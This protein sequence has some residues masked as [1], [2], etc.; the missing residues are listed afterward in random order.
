M[1][2]DDNWQ[3]YKIIATGDGEKLEK[4]GN[5]T[6]LRPDPQAIWHAQKPLKEYKGLSAR[7]L[8]SDTGGG[9]WEYFK[10]ID[11]W[12]VSW[13]NL[14]FAV[15]P[16]GFKH[17][18][19]F[20]EQAVNWEIMINLIKNAQK[21]VRVLNLFA[22]TGGATVACAYAGAEVCHVDAAKN[23][24]DRAKQN[25]RLSGL[26]D[27][28]V[29]YIVDDC[30]KF[31]AREIKRGK[32]Y[33]AVILDPPSYGRGANG[34][35]WKLENDIADFLQLVK[36]VLTPKP[37]FVLLNSYTTGLQPTVLKNLLNS[38]LKGFDGSTEAYEVCL[39]TQEDGIFLPCGASGLF[40]GKNDKR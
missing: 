5:V 36:G 14:T 9:R 33:D 13:K 27:K 25:V 2:Y 11:E 21:P 6:L 10:P 34:E 19:L 3:D 1:R 17:T 40:I 24:V 20:P 26:S 38:A 28:L 35:V 30:A 12:T 32:F 16:M 4:W 29:R 7:Y 15:K 39:P 18:G 31:V 23:M 37:L 22:Y 8:R